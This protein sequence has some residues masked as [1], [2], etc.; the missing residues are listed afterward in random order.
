MVN[1]GVMYQCGDSV[2][3]DFAKAYKWYR[4]GLKNGN[5][6]ANYYIGYLYYKGFGVE[7]SYKTALH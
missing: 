3:Q 5:T 6:K 2:A 4:R 1:I 7:Q